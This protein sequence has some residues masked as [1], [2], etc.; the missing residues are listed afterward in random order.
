[1]HKCHQ[2]RKQNSANLLICR[3]LWYLW[4]LEKKKL[5]IETSLGNLEPNLCLK[6]KM[7]SQ[8]LGHKQP[9]R[10][11]WLQTHKQKVLQ[12]AWNVAEMPPEQHRQVKLDLVDIM[13]KE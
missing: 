9:N 10:M 3:E 2:T 7:N 13:N 6:Y 4:I 5:E 8:I 12:L 11:R 1:L